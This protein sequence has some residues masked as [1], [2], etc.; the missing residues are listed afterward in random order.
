MSQNQQAFLDHKAALSFT[1]KGGLDST[2]DWFPYCLAKTHGGLPMSLQL[3]LAISNNST[4]TKAIKLCP[5]LTSENF[6]I[7][8]Y[9]WSHD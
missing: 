9:K 4:G 6:L 2:I 5:S 1:E 3:D 7:C 8:H